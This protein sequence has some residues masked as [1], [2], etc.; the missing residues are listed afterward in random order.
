ML[1]RFPAIALTLCVAAALAAQSQ[2]SDKPQA[3]LPDTQKSAV[4]AAVARMARVGSAV[5]PGFLL[6]ASG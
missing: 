4:A 1:K 3:S 2:P 6:T 5:A